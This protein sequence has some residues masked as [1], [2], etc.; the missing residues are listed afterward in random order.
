MKLLCILLAVWVGLAA[1]IQ[2]QS[3]HL[4]DNTPKTAPEPSA[5]YLAIYQE[6]RRLY[7]AEKF[8]EALEQVRVVLA[9]YPHY[10]PAVILQ[11]QIERQRRTSSSSQMR[12]KLDR[13]I[14]PRVK[15]KDAIVESA[16][17]FLRDETRRLDP[18]K[19]GV[20]FV[21]NLPDEVKSRKVTLDLIDVSASD[22]LKYMSE[23]A[24]FKYRIDRSAVIITANEPTSTPAATASVESA[25]PKPAIPGAAP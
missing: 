18:E 12:T 10:Q 17:D 25:E 16:L 5:D 14:I 21:P 8:D 11:T 6:A 7:E 9:K 4:G 23:V 3:H 15:F 22:V 13:I 20:N 19:K 2:A 1:S 24:G